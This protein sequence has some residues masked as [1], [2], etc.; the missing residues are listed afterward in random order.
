MDDPDLQLLRG[1]R[2]DEAEPPPG[3]QGRIEER[4][5][6]SILQE[7]ARTARG[8][9]RAPARTGWL[10]GLLR[11]ALAGGMA[12]SLALGVAVVSDGGSGPGA[13]GGSSVTQAN[14]LDRTASTLFGGASST[15]SSAAP[16]VGTI[17]LRSEDDDDTLVGGPLHDPSTGQLDATTVE[18]VDAMPRDPAQ[19]LALVREGVEQA[20]FDDDADALA[21]RVAMRW[22]VDASVP[23]DL[24]AS[25]LRA[26]GGLTGIDEARSGVDVLGRGGIVIGHL[27]QSSGV[28]TQVVLDPRAGTL[29]EVRAFTTTYVDPACE[30]GTFTEHSVYGDDGSQV[31][32]ASLP[33]VDWPLVVEACGDVTG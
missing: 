7:E 17:D 12:L 30:P 20:G 18:M 33:W 19:L 32:P 29:R 14:V 3:M 24:R 13:A 1:F 2:A 4:L 11:P 6:Q 16:I 22:I 8:H 26:L 15:T 31:E 5:W 21:F 27:D 9:R 25:M 10:S 23:V 28:R